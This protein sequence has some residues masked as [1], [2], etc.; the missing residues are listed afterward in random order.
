MMDRREKERKREM[1]EGKGRGKAR[2]GGGEGG[3]AKRTTR[4]GSLRNREG[5]GNSP[6][7]AM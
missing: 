2:S 6:E 3:A 5:R 1:G 4:G 7:K